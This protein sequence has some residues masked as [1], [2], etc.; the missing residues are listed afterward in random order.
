MIN[1]SDAICNCR[2]V[3]KAMARLHK[4]HDPPAHTHLCSRN[5]MLNPS[6]MGIFIADYN[7]K[8]LKMVA[9]LFSKYSNLNAWTSPEVVTDP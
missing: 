7:L 3:A 2:N 9:K 6:D 1:L 5:I 4:E 8:T